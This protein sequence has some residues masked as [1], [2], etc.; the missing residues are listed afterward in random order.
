MFL[1]Q[2]SCSPEPGSQPALSA[3]EELL[4]GL[5]LKAE[6]FSNASWNEYWATHGPSLL[7]CGWTE[8]HP[9][10]PL[11]RLQ[12]VCALDCLAQTMEQLVLGN[13]DHQVIA[14]G[15]AYQSEGTGNGVSHM[16]AQVISEELGGV[17]LGTGEMEVGGGGHVTDHVTFEEAG[18]GNGD[19][20]S[21]SEGL[22]I[23]E[24]GLGNGSGHVTDHVTS[25]HVTSEGLG[26]GE[27]G[28]GNGGH[29]AAEEAELTVVEGDRGSNGNVASPSGSDEEVAA[30]WTEHYNTY[31]W[32]CYQAFLSNQSCP[33]SSEDGGGEDGNDAMEEGEGEGDGVAEMCEGEGRSEVMEVAALSVVQDL[34]EEM[35]SCVVERVAADSLSNEGLAQPTTDSEAE[36]KQ[37]S[38]N[39]NTRTSARGRPAP[40]AE[41]AEKKRYSRE[42]LVFVLAHIKGVALLSSHLHLPLQMPNGQAHCGSVSSAWLQGLAQGDGEKV[43]VVSGFCVSSFVFSVYVAF[44]YPFPCESSQRFGRSSSKARS[45]RGR[46]GNRSRGNCNDSRNQWRS[47]HSCSL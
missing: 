39:T 14:E 12:R 8:V 2:V 22:G 9:N 10:I 43:A 36:D 21:G 18:V 11:H 25:D 27:A 23:G 15:L 19:H 26:T 4:E 40:L 1:L 32:Y 6:A 38:T 33:G 41:S 35:V 24:A 5:R 46:G 30:L 17:G 3:E 20:M 29:M 37:H 7:A 13:G 16:T 42:Q 45:T 34:V 47:S 31:Y 28:V 44:Q